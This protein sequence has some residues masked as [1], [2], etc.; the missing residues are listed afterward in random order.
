MEIYRMR[1]VRSTFSCV[2]FWVEM[3][4]DSMSTI[5]VCAILSVMS[6]I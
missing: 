3:Y 2:T 4:A 1:P 6:F 5:S